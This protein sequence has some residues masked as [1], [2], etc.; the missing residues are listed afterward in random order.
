[1]L[2]LRNDVFALVYDDEDM[3]EHLMIYEKGN[4]KPLYQDFKVCTIQVFGNQGNEAQYLIVVK[5]KEIY[6]LD[7]RTYEK[8]TIDTIKEGKFT[9]MCIYSEDGQARIAVS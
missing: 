6:C 2:W 3:Q 5:K 1:M 4:K 8:N 7:L 9:G